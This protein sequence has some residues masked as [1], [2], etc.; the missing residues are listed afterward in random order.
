MFRM[1]RLIQ[2]HL[3]K[4]LLNLISIEIF[5]ARERK[6]QITIDTWLSTGTRPNYL[7]IVFHIQP[8]KNCYW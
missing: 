5:S 6:V 7:A 8:A 3:S 1:F 4:S 2:E